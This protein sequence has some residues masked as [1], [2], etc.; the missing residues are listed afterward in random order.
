MKF[1]INKKHVSKYEYN[2]KIIHLEWGLQSIRWIAW[3]IN[4][5]W[6]EKRIDFQRYLQ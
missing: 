5:I 4:R 2:L 6:I 3:K 1:V